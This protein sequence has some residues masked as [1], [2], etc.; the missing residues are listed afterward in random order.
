MKVVPS[1]EAEPLPS[2]DAENVTASPST[3]LAA[4]V[5]TK[6]VSSATV[7]VPI[8]STTGASLTWI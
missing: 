4:R 2:T 7:C 1:T 8:T 6:S 3:S 5:K